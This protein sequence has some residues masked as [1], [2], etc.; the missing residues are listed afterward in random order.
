MPP[1]GGLRHGRIRAVAIL[2]SLASALAIAPGQTLAQDRFVEDVRVS[3]TGDRAEIMIRLG[4]QM[5]YQADTR[6]DAGAMIEVR[7]APFDTCRQLG[8]STAIRSEL[9]RPIGGQ[10]AHLV[11]IEFES[12]GIGDSLLMLRF[13]RPVDYRVRQRGD[14]RTLQVIVELDAAA[15]FSATPLPESAPGAVSPVTAPESREDGPGQSRQPRDRQPL[16]VRVV[17]PETSADY[18]INLRSTR[19][20]A[21]VA[22]RPAIDHPEGLRLY[23]SQTEI[24]GVPWFRLRLGYFASEDEALAALEPLR[25]AYPRAWVGRAEPAEIEAASAFRFAAGEEKLGVFVA[26]EGTGAATT[27]GA[28]SAP[29]PPERIAELEAAGRSAMLDEDYAAAVAA[30]SEL[31]RAP[32]EHRAAAVE[33]LGVAYER[34]GDLAQARAQYEQFLRDFAED[35]E[36]S[37]RVEQRLAGVMMID[38]MPAQSL[39]VTREEPARWDFATGVAQYYRRGDNQFD[40]DQPEVTTLSALF[41]DID[42]SLRRFGS[43]FDSSTR[44]TLS[45]MRDLLPDDVRSR[46]DQE[47]ISYA[48]SELAAADGAWSVRLGRQSLHNWGVLGRFDGAHFA[49]DWAAGRELHFTAGYPVESTRDSV[50]TDRQFYGVA[51]ELEELFGQWDLAAFLNTQTI[52]GVDARKA[53]GTELRYFD[54]RR[55]FTGLVDYDL[56]FGEVN[57]LLVLGTWRLANRLTLSALVDDRKSPILTTRNALIGQPVGTIEELLLVW[58]EE[59]VRQLAADRTA[60]SR[61][62]TLGLATPLAERFQLNFDAT[63]S[64]ITG[65]SASGG[66]ASIPG[67]GAQTFYSASLVGTSL[68]RN[69]DVMILNLRVGESETFSTGVLTWDARFPVGARLRINPRVR[70]LV[71]EGLLD[72]RRRETV[73]PMLRLVMNTRSHYRI[74]LEVG[75]DRQTRMDGLVERE[76]SGRFVNFGYRANF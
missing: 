74:E 41:S 32:G 61:T 12:L 33:F 51:V 24:D 56:D 69:G 64:E 37:M 26:D 46:G 47:R 58:T 21:D 54:D 28:L 34:S 10:I 23:V 75:V 65:T 18:M 19:E 11:D 5:R 13:D 44:I 70:F 7:V 35:P 67:T 52:D 36:G 22:S 14:L 17:E 50:E 31:A 2:I 43:R 76:A 8:A 4:C 73:S 6:I 57:T 20:L 53:V 72:G 25:E 27:D 60:E 42:F 29:L 49:Y 68:V 66:V 16:S 1:G 63:R 39:R 71:W 48:Y 30:Y 38:A 40:E 15:E 59:E 62:V 9:Y 55:S 45:H 3:R